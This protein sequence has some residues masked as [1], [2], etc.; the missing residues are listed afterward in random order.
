MNVLF[1]KH[2]AMPLK[3][4]FSNTFSTTDLA[5]YDEFKSVE[6]L[7]NMDLHASTDFTVEKGKNRFPNSNVVA[8]AI[9][10]TARSFYHLLKTL[11]NSVN[12]VLS[13][14]IASMKALESHNTVL[15]KA[16]KTQMQ[17]LTNV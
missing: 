9:Q 16:M 6:A 8:K 13:I 3:K 4:V 1:K 17:L 12:R 15:N 14:S 5:V 7:A 10:K 11:N 2:S